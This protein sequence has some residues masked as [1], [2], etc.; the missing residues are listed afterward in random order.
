MKQLLRTFTYA[1]N[2]GKHDQAQND[3]SHLQYATI[4]I[5]KNYLSKNFLHFSDD[6]PC[7]EGKY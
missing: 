5:Y 3:N 7:L 6:V 4:I 1:K 2:F